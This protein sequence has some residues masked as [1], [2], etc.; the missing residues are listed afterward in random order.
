M[1]I[2][3]LEL[4]TAWYIGTQILP[5]YLPQGFGALFFFYTLPGQL[6]MILDSLLFNGA[7]FLSSFLSVKFTRV[8]LSALIAGFIFDIGTTLFQSQFTGLNL[9]RFL[10]LIAGTIIMAFFLR[11]AYNNLARKRL[12]YFL[13]IIF[14]IIMQISY[15]Y[16]IL[17]RAA[18]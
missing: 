15:N 8:T 11:K 10:P 3:V 2:L 7:K 6:F 1:T 4:F 18:F 12:F 9:A 16:L 5:V 13:A 14:P 17:Y